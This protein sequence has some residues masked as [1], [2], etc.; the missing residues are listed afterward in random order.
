MDP[1]PVEMVRLGAKLDDPLVIEIIERCRRPAAVW[2]YCV[3]AAIDAGADVKDPVVIAAAERSDFMAAE[4]HMFGLATKKKKKPVNPGSIAASP[5]ILIGCDPSLTAS[6]VAVLERDQFGVYTLLRHG[7]CRTKATDGVRRLAEIRAMVASVADYPPDDVI[8]AGVEGNFWRR[9]Q[10]IKAALDHAE[11]IGVCLE[12]LTSAGFPTFRIAP[13]QAKLSLT[14]SGKA[15]KA[16][17]VRWAEKTIKGAAWI[18][19]PFKYYREAVADAI[20]NALAAEKEAGILAR[21]SQ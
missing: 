17:M 5:T 9:G 10:S 20:G 8:A 1:S 15:D 18:P 19:I 21:M 14:G 13:R 12:C 16:A 7:C 4:R 3:E 6:G 11:S 2:G